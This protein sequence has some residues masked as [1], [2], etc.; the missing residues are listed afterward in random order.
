METPWE[1]ALLKRNSI[2]QSEGFHPDIE[3]KHGA[4]VLKH[5]V[6]TSSVTRCLRVS[7]IKNWAGGTR[8]TNEPC[9]QGPLLTVK[10]LGLANLTPC[11][12]ESEHQVLAICEERP[13]K[14][15]LGWG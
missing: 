12:G 15:G 14:Q 2:P 6:T 11:K 4:V 13:Q 3:S 1:Y 8:G 7:A 10:G 5:Q 9:V